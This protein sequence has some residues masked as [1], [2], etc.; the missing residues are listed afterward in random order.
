MNLSPSYM[1]ESRSL[2]AAA[3]NLYYE[4]K[5]T[6]H[7]F[8]KREVHSN[9]MEVDLMNEPKAGFFSMLKLNVS[10]RASIDVT[11]TPGLHTGITSTIVVFLRHYFSLLP[12]G[13]RS[14]SIYTSLGLSLGSAHKRLNTY[15][16]ELQNDLFSS[17]TSTNDDYQKK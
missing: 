17:Y 16:T 1:Q 8:P 5:G 11:N 14:S 12:R 15:A 3:N 6:I 10:L 13:L 9:H 2:S 4:I 7:S